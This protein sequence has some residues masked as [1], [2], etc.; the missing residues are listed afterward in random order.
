MKAKFYQHEIYA[1]IEPP[2]DMQTEDVQCHHVPTNNILFIDEQNQCIVRSFSPVP[3]NYFYKEFAY[4][5][6]TW[7]L[8]IFYLPHKQKATTFPAL[9]VTINLAN[10]HQIHLIKFPFDNFVLHDKTMAIDT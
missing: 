8:I 5:T 2:Y 6:D 10:V 3:L 9:S 1:H 7:V 4:Q